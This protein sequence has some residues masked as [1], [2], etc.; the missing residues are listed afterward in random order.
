MIG[1]PGGC[2]R[3]WYRP[4][5][6]V[7]DTTLETPHTLDPEGRRSSSEGGSASG[8]EQSFL[9]RYVWWIIGVLIVLVSIAV[10]RW[11]NTRPGYDPYGWLVWGYQLL[12]WNLNLGGAP[13]WKP[14]PLLATAPFALF[15]HNALYLWM[16]LS[17]AVSFSGTVFAARIAYR[18]VNRDGRHLWPAV[19]AALIAGLGM[20]G[21]Q[22]NINGT[23]DPYLH[24][25]LSVQSDPMIVSLVL[26]AI[27]FH[28][29]GRRRWVIAM[30][31]LAGLGRPE[32]WPI[33]GLY[34]LWCWR[35]RPDMRW[36][37]GISLV[38]LVVLWFGVP[39]ITNGR[40]LLAGDLAQGSPRELHQNKI[41]GTIDRF[42]TLN[43]W[44][45]WLVA[46]AAVAW[47][48]VRWRRL[49]A[50]M[51]D[52]AG[53][54]GGTAQP[55]GA[56]PAAADRLL[57]L[58]LAAGVLIWLVVEIAFAIHGWPAVPRYI[59]EPA[60]V[61]VLLAG[62]GFGWLLTEIP[63]RLGV[64]RAAGIVLA[65][66]LF[67][68]LIPAG[69]TRLRREHKDLHDQQ[70]RTTE[71][72]KLSTYIAG[73]GGPARIEACGG[74]LVNV[75]YVSVMAFDLNQSTGHVAYQPRK[76]LLRSNPVIYF[77]PFPNG[78]GATPLRPQRA[79]A[80]G[81]ASLK[82]LYVPTAR[83]PQGVLVPK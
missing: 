50:G 55:A 72:N 42:K 7:S 22:D 4:W 40:P 31:V 38:L 32:A 60:A 35:H 23:L 58:G 1:L 78:W 43:L 64:P 80:A 34:S 24:Y 36:F 51:P 37:I 71:I 12:H 3:G 6:L 15:G 57:V 63:L 44:P 39:W 18:V 56:E 53:E 59:F 54:P 69:I 8:A 76:V 9:R 48:G 65:A 46:L 82:S 66:A 52:G 33:L 79:N 5:L 16:V 2:G 30:L 26:A 41:I 27:D 45:V 14:L 75:E 81:C 25:V 83:H 67:V 47:A 20:Y 28:M 13:S 68:C 77:V 74:A 62:I 70:A 17:V 49:R 19:V 21:I 11:A 29:S 61:V 10:V 73:L